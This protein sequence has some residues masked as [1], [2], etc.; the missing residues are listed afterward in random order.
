[1]DAQVLQELIWIRWLL[2]VLVFTAVAM[3]GYAAWLS[4]L[5]VRVQ[6]Q[7]KYGT[8]FDR[9]NALLNK[10]ELQELLV[11]CD[12]RVLEYPGDAMAYW[13][14]ANAHYRL[15]NL[16]R[17][18]I[19]YRKAEELQPGLG[20]SPMISEIEERIAKGAKSP[21]LKVV[22]PSTSLGS[23]A[24]AHDGSPRGVDG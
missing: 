16:N 19:C 18:L 20:I 17:A 23:G 24:P 14:M 11:L 21:D 4:V 7:Q 15:S 8:F 1:M 3:V 12:E 2:I 9:G 5:A 10:G 13:L 6:E 22:G